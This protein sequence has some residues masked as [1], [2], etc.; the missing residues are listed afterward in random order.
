VIPIGDRLALRDL[1]DTY[2]SAVD[3]RDEPAFR[4][5][6]TP[7]ARLTTHAGDGPPEGDFTGADDIA[8][9]ITIIQRYQLTF[10]LVANHVVRLDP[11]GG[12]GGREATGEAYCIGHHLTPT[13]GGRHDDY[14]MGIR[15]LDR[16]ARDDAGAWRFAAREVRRQWTRHDTVDGYPTPGAS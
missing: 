14:V 3:R 15:Y 6:W 12:R 1:V 8:R 2:A 5:L 11:G 16:Y 7:D 10:H 13:D 9:V 4:A